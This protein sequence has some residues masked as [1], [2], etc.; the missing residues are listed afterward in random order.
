MGL[1]KAYCRVYQWIYNNESGQ[2][3]GA[4]ALGGRG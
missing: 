4:G 3:E 2:M 1:K